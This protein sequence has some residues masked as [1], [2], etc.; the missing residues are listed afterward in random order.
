MLSW[1]GSPEFHFVLVVFGFVMIVLGLRGYSR[2]TLSRSELL[3]VLVASVAWIAY[4]IA[5]ATA[6]LSL[7]NFI[8][9]LLTGFLSLLFILLFFYWGYMRRGGEGD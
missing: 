6:F 9:S 8:S 4:S 7:P 2:G 3:F 5:D 1:V